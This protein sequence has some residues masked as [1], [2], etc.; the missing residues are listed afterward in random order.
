MNKSDHGQTHTHGHIT[1]AWVAA[2]IHAP[3]HDLAYVTLVVDDAPWP[4]LW[5]PRRLT[6]HSAMISMPSAPRP[7]HPSRS[8]ANDAA[9]SS[10][11]MRSPPRRST[12]CSTRPQLATLIMHQSDQR[13][14]SSVH[15]SSV[16][17]SPSHAL[18]TPAR[19]HDHALT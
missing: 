18:H 14:R 8:D 5:P 12:P 6:L 15:R 19:A 16:F 1:W 11:A 3:S 2:N 7:A 10:A 13:G 17:S 9:V 4:L